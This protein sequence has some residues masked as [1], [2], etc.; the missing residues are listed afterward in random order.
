M[1]LYSI[2]DS[3]AVAYR[4]L[5]AADT[6]GLAS[7]MVSDSVAG[8]DL[9]RYPEDFAVYCLGEWNVQSGSISP[10]VPPRHVVAVGALVALMKAEK[11]EYDN[12]QTIGDDA[13][14][15]SGAEGDDPEEFF[16]TDERF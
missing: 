12:G 14:V 15:Q 9:G 2:Y 6:D 1:K 11:G 8:T 5:F 7:R 16:Q 4:S 3:K 10:L 13:S